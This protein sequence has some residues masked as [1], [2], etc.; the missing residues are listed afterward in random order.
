M[1]S[2]ARRGEDEERVR[3]GELGGDR[4]GGDDGVVEGGDGEEGDLDVGGVLV[5]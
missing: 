5:G 2:V 4:R 3:F 1:T